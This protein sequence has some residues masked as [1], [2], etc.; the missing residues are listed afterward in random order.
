MIKLLGKFSDR[1]NAS[2]FQKLINDCAQELPN[3]SFV[4]RDPAGFFRVAPRA[5]V[6][7]RVITAFGSLGV[8]DRK[9]MFE[10]AWSRNIFFLKKAGS[11]FSIIATHQDPSKAVEIRSMV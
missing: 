11:K 6:E 5:V 3:S 2:R 9:V 7:D 8:D 4:P 1:L 10:K